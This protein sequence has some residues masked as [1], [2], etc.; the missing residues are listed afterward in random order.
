MKTWAVMG[1]N[2]I[3]IEVHHAAR[4]MAVVARLPGVRGEDL[5]I[6]LT[7]QELSIDAESAQG[8]LHY[9]LPL[10][11]PVDDRRVT[12]E[13]ASGVLRIYLPKLDDGRT[14]AQGLR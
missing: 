6:G 2:I 3:P 1:P 8:A 12:M 4:G 14:R 10:P 7:R 11:S 9:A 13:F 5:R